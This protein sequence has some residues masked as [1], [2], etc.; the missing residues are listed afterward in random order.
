MKYQI[1]Q[2]IDPAMLEQMMGAAQQQQ[3]QQQVPMDMS[4]ENMDKSY[5]EQFEIIESKYDSRI[6]ELKKKAEKLQERMNEDPTN[7]MIQNQLRI[8]MV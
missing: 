6:N 2:Q 5:A 1:G 8:I 7:K 3:V 4:P